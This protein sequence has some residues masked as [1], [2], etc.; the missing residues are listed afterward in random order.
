M[1]LYYLLQKHKRRTK[2]LFSKG[3]DR[4]RDLVI[5][6]SD[7]L[8]AIVFAVI[9]T[10]GAGWLAYTCNSAS[11]KHNPWL[12]AVIAM[13]FPEIYIAQFTIRAAVPGAI[14]CGKKDII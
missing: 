10:L 5:P 1:L 8:A 11:K 12:V 9:I 13:L 3:H 14:K 7:K 6:G 4:L 2:S